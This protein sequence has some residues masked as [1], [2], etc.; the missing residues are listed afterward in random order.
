VPLPGPPSPLSRRSSLPPLLGHVAGP[1]HTHHTPPLAQPARPVARPSVPQPSLARSH[2]SAATRTQSHARPSPSAARSSPTLESPPCLY[3]AQARSPSCLGLAPRPASPQPARRD[4]HAPHR[5]RHAASEAAAIARG[6]RVSGSLLQL[7]TRDGCPR[8]PHLHPAPRGTRPRRRETR[9]LHPRSPIRASAPPLLFPPSFSPITSTPDASKTVAQSSPRHLRRAFEAHHRN[10]RGEMRPRRSSSQQ[11][12][13]CPCTRKRRYRRTRRRSR[14]VAVVC[15]QHVCMVSVYSFPA[16]SLSFVYPSLCP[17]P[18]QS[19][20]ARWP[21]VA[22]LVQPVRQ[23]SRLAHGSPGMASALPRRA[24]LTHDLPHCALAANVAP[25]ARPCFPLVVTLLSP[26]VR[27][28]CHRNLSRVERV[29]H[30]HDRV[31]YLAR[32]TLIVLVCCTSHRD[33]VNHSI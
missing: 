15:A 26:R 6:T 7:P 14:F 18:G 22:R 30:P 3:S 13:A 25:Q 12:R 19:A 5:T 20:M 1:P 9:H 21:G 33:S 16:Y 24:R 17:Y 4:A 31:R 23:P 11:P 2:A 27:C 8:R 10:H 28:G 29:V 32:S